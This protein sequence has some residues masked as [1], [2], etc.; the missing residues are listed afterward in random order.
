MKKCCLIG[1]RTIKDIEVVSKQLKEIL[2]NLIELKK[3]K[4]FILGNNGEFNALAYTTLCFLK[5][6]KYPEIKIISYSLNNEY[7]YTHE[8]AERYFKRAKISTAKIFDV[9]NYLNDID[10]TQIKRAYVLR[11]KTI[12]ENSDYCIFYYKED[13]ALPNNRNSGT[14]IAV[15]FAKQLNKNIILI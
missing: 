2:I 14:K 9:I 7:T 10:E 3:V 6:Q 8:E 15:E 5:E 1:H 13:Y 11:N 12:I 4:N